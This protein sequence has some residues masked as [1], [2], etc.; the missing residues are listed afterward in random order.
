MI[1]DKER[2]QHS[3]L[4]FRHRHRVVAVNVTLYADNHKTKAMR[5]LKMAVFALSHFDLSEKS[6]S[7]SEKRFIFALQ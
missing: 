5:R 7:S 3:T 6:L 2:W 1:V 4:I